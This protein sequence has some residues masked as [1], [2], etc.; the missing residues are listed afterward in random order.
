MQQKH[1]K[2]EF[3]IQQKMTEFDTEF[4]TE[5]ELTTKLVNQYIVLIQHRMT[6]ALIKEKGNIL[7]VL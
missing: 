4:S 5:L 3:R 7:M 1:N 2:G 6:T